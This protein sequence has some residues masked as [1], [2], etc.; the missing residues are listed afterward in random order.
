MSYT[1]RHDPLSLWDATETHS[2]LVVNTCLCVT[3]QTPG[4]D[5][6]QQEIEA[7]AS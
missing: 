1:S 6:I 3:Q 5:K 2:H 7:S 4:P